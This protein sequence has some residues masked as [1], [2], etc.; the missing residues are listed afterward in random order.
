MDPSGTTTTFLGVADQGDSHEHMGSFMLWRYDVEEDTFSLLQ[1]INMDDV[2]WVEMT[3]HSSDLFL[4][5]VSGA[6]RGDQQGQVHIYRMD[7]FDGD[8][9]Q[10]LGHYGTVVQSGEFDRL[11]A[12]RAKPQFYFVQEVAVEEPVEAR[13]YTL[14][15]GELNLYVIKQDGIVVRFSQKGIHRFWKEGELHAPGKVTLDVWSSWVNGRIVQRLNAGGSSCQ[16]LEKK[17]FPEEPAV[18]LEALIRGGVDSQGQ[19]SCPANH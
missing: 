10:A 4:V 17:N 7:W 14:P 6:F 2:K 5:V 1:V 19:P 11:T 13:F 16:D 3:S 15:S 8:G 12:L 18:V 9:T